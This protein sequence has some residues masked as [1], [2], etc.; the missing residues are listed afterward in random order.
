M[1]IDGDDQVDEDEEEEDEN[2]EDEEGEEEVNEDQ[3]E[4]KDEVDCKQ[5]WTI[6]EGEMVNTLDDDVDTRVENQS[7]VLPEQSQEIRKYTPRPQPPLPTPQPHTVESRPRPRTTETH[8]LRGLDHLGLVT[9]QNSRPA[10]PTLQEPEAAGNT[11]HLNADVDVDVDGDQQLLI[12]LVV[13]DSLCDCPVP[14]VPLPDLHLPDVLR[15]DVPP[16]EQCVDGLVG[17]E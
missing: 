2:K 16:P 11:L 10:V 15:L 3:K 14:D 7:I 6:I 17:E 4:D 12:E 1:D 5:P 9:A 13:G 8:P